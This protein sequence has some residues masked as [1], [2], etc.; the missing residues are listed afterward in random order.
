[1]ASEKTYETRLNAARKARGWSHAE[2]GRRLG[3]TRQTALAYC[4]GR[5]APRSA[6]VRRRLKAAFDGAVDAGNFDELIDPE[7]GGGG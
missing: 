1:M 5:R 6:V 3:V 7:T 4:K 2:L